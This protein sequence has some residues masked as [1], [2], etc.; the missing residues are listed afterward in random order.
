MK[1]KKYSYA[2][3]IALLLFTGVNKTFAE[4]QYCYYMSNGFRIRASFEY[5]IDKD[6]PNI[7]HVGETTASIDEIDGE[8]NY[9]GNLK[10]DNWRDELSNTTDECIAGKKVCF[11]Y[12]HNARELFKNYSKESNKPQCPKY[13]VYQQSKWK[14]VFGTNDANLASQAAS[15]IREK[16]YPGYYATKVNSYADYFKKEI[17]M[18]E[19]KKGNDGNWQ[20]TELWADD[21]IFGNPNQEGT[22]GN[23][24]KK[25]MQIV[26]IIV[27]I[28]IILLG[29]LDLSKAV[30]AGKE[31][32]MK[33]A[34]KTFIKRIIAGVAVFFVPVLV[35]IIMSFTDYVWTGTG[36]KACPFSDVSK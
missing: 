31:D 10:I 29:S 18:G 1:L 15:A 20:C 36:Y 5:S 8:D 26:R 35:S 23:L 27:P 9:I 21:G 2:I 11:G 19:I 6:N 32:E 28:L 22:V 7:Y 17:A 3:V 14:W 34:Q 12:L 13:L 24:I 16:G 4:T 33:K 25:G 30:F